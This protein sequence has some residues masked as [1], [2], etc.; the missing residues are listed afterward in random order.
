MKSFSKALVSG[1]IMAQLNGLDLGGNQIG[2]EGMK[3]FS[4]A[5]ASG[6]LAQLECISIDEPTDELEAICVQ[7]GIA[8]DISR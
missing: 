3:S 2:D 8:I 6:A 4:V 7:R 5:L 1:A